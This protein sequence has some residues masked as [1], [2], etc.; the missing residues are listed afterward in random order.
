MMDVEDVVAVVVVVVVVVD[1]GCHDEAE[2]G[3]IFS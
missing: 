3:I 1:I 2:S